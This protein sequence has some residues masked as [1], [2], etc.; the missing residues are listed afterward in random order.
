MFS[1]FVASSSVYLAV[2][3]HKVYIYKFWLHEHEDYF[4]KCVLLC[5]ISGLIG[6][7][8]SILSGNIGSEI[9]KTLR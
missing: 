7:D 5:H 8:K 9:M 1:T 4:I 3:G 2:Y 6:K